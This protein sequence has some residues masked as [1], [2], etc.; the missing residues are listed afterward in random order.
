MSSD[1][2]DLKQEEIDR[3]RER[4]REGRSLTGMIDSDAWRA[5]RAAAQGG[6]FDQVCLDHFSTDV[7]VL[8]I[9]CGEAETLRRY[10]HPNRSGELVGV[11]IS[12]E[13]MLRGR[14]G[15]TE[16]VELITADA[17]ELPFADATF[18]VI[19]AATCLH[20]LPDWQHAILREVRRVLASSGV[21]IFSD[22]LLYNPLSFA[23]R[24][25]LETR[26]RSDAEVPLNPFTLRRTL[27]SSFE[28]VHLD[29]F[30]LVS[31]AVAMMD[32]YVPFSPGRVAVG[33]HR[34]EQILFEKGLYPLA[35]SVV[36]V[37]ESP[38]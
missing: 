37:A 38:R 31:P 14:Q 27:E 13:E 29:W 7:D 10:S 25:V 19:V 32:K 24:H 20:H 21:F 3:Y 4:S 35:G 2:Q 17:E 28:T 34:V 33:M 36:G 5:L 6:R 1:H 9:G 26:D 15:S 8:S 12:T 30:Y 23:A 11:D 18:D 22:P 16:A